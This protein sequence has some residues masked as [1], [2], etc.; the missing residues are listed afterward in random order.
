MLD[1]Y[2]VYVEDLRRRH[3]FAGRIIDD[4]TQLPGG[5]LDRG[6][7]AFYLRTDLI[8][9]YDRSKELPF[10]AIEADRSPDPNTAGNCNCVQHDLGPGRVLLLSYVVQIEY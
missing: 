6:A 10:S 7:K 9:G 1:Q 3:C 8:F 4:R 2:E 5:G